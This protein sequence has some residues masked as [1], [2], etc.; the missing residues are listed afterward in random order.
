MTNAIKAAN[1]FGLIASGVKVVPLS[2][3]LQAIDG[4]GGLEATAGHDH[5]PALVPR[6][7]SAKSEAFADEFE[8]RQGAMAPYLMAGPLFRGADLSLGGEGDRHRRSQG[9]LR[10]DAKSRRS[11]TPSP[12]TACCGPTAAWCTTSIWCR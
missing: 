4:A 11:T 6:C 5:G 1:E 7:Q 3:D 12:S 9:D 10:L 8:K 2:M